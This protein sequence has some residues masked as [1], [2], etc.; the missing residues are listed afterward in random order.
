MLGKSFNLQLGVTCVNVETHSNSAEFL[1]V[2]LFIILMGTRDIY[3]HKN[4]LYFVI[5]I[6]KHRFHGF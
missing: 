1:N 3:V 6:R 5:S 2:L 4:K